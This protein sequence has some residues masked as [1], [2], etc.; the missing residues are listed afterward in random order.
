MGVRSD[1]ALFVVRSST[2]AGPPCGNGSSGSRAAARVLRLLLAVPFKSTNLLA[3]KPLPPMALVCRLLASTGLAKSSW[4]QTRASFLP[5][6]TGVYRDESQVHAG[7][8]LLG[9]PF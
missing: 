6:T 1:A 7:R 2:E 4:G 5:S 9:K 8:K 3:T